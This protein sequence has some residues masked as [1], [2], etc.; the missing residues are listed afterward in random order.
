MQRVLGLLLLISAAACGAAATPA[1]GAHESLPSQPL[2]PDYKSNSGP[3]QRAP[4][5]AGGAAAQAPA[6]TTDALP[7]AATDRMIIRTANLSLTVKDATAAHR[8]SALPTTNTRSPQYARAGA[9]ASVRADRVGLWFEQ[10]TAR[11]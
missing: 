7:A 11:F 1:P 4:A 3:A 9:A 2:P 5:P 10:A 6:T 8:T